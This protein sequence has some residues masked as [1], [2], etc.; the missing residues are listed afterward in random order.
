M[1]GKEITLTYDKN[2][3]EANALLDEAINNDPQNAEFMNL[4][5]SLV[6]H[7][8]SIEEALQYFEKAVE[9]VKNGF[10]VIIFKKVAKILKKGCNFVTFL[11]Y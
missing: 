10:F 3:D 9:L 2:Y 8:S 6:E 7:Q 11:L 1:A 5:G 4:K